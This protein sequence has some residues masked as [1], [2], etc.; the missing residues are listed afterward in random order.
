MIGDF[1]CGDVGVLKKFSGGC[2]SGS[3]KFWGDYDWW[4]YCLSLLG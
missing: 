4:K 3:S 1:G 2:V